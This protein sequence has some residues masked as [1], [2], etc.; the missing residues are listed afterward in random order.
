MSARISYGNSTFE[1][2][3]GESVLDCLTRNGISVPH[4]CRSGVCQS[5]LMHA[6]EG[7][8]PEAAQKDLQPA[9]IKQDMFLACQCRPDDDMRVAPPDHALLD[10]HAVISAKEMLNHNVMRVRLTTP[11]PYA[12][13]PGQYV[14]VL[15][16]DGIARSYSVANNP[17][18]DH[19]I[20]LHVRLLKDG[21]MS[22]F[23]IRAD[24]GESVI[25]R[26][27]AGKCFY[28]AEG[29]RDYPLLLAG[30]GTGLAPL[31]GILRAALAQGHGGAIH[32]FHGVLSE[33][34]LYLDARL[35]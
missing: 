4:A 24:V 32:L 31:Y 35:R 26:G 8:I 5:C 19:V 25:V 29:A 18:E 3:A 10:T 16:A 30:T 23:L 15:T 33:P 1:A 28:V 6:V 22:E 20:E 34:D 13:E 9:Y 14:T 21:A 7:Q 12:C 11:T 17:G 2:Q 27:P